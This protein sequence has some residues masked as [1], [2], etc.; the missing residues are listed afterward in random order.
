MDHRC[1]ERHPV[2]A[3]VLLRRRSWAG[4]IVG[5]L[6]NVSVSGA[7]LRLH[8]GSLPLHALVRLEA[9]FPGPGAPRL[10]HCNAMVARVARGG[11]GLVFDEL[12]PAS[13]APLFTVARQPAAHRSR[14]PRPGAG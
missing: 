9:P 8:A 1:G 4:W 14:Q 5:E 10:M 3:T 6:E 13:L 7:F 2:R 12:A 11:V